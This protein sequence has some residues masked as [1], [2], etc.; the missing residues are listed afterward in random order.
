MDMIRSS[1]DL[2]NL[3]S[4]ISEACRENRQPVC[5]TANGRG[6]TGLLGMSEYDQMKAELELLGTLVDA[7]DDVHAGRVAPIEDTFVD[8]RKSLLVR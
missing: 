7:E 3:Y 1:D 6:E 4:E 5:I 8:I 2:R